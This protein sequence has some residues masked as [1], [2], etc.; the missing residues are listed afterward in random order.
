MAKQVVDPLSLA[1][2][3]LAPGL[4]DPTPKVLF[5]SAA[6]PGFFKGKTQAV[7]TAA[8]L[9]EERRWVEGTGEWV[10]RGASKQQKYRLTPEGVRAILEHSETLTLLRSLAGALGQQVA[11][12]HALRDQLNVLVHG[13][14]PLAETVGHLSRRIEPPDVEQLLRKLQ[15]GPRAPA[16]PVSPCPADK[17]SDS[18][19]HGEVV[20]LV[21]EQHQRNRYQSLSLPQLYAAIRQKRPTLSLGQFHDGLRLLREQGKIRLLPFTRAL[22]TIDDP[23]NALFYDGEVMYYA[24]LP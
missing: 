2:Q 13:L 8:R 5:G 10:G 24:D 18:E 1:L 21:A 7:K 15:D 16:P 17:A 4:A 22:A 11:H 3:A 19:W 14:Q 23:R 20:R 12:F 9:C 6:N